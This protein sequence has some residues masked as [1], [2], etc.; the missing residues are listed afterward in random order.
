MKTYTFWYSE[1]YTFKAG[2]HANSLEEAKEL[3]GKAFD[4]EI[5]LEELP[6][7]WHKG[8]DYEMEY[9]AETIEEWED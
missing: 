6:D 1:T 3:I 4:G 5:D 9:L 8:K 2:F 7:F